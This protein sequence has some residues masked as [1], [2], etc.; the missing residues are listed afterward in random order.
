MM[1]NSLSCKKECIEEA[2]HGNQMLITE[3]R[4]RAIVGNQK[5]LFPH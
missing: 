1:E 3:I 2:V 5:K 4:G